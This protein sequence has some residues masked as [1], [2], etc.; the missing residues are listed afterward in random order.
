[1]ITSV[2]T[3]HGEAVAGGVFDGEIFGGEIVGLDQQAGCSF[4]LSGE[5]E[6][7]FVH[8]LA[9]DG[10]AVG[11]ERER[12]VEMELAFGEIDHVSGLGLD[13]LLLQMLLEFCRSLAG[14]CR[15]PGEQGQRE[16]EYKSGDRESGAGH[17]FPRAV[18]RKLWYTRAV[19]SG[20]A[21]CGFTPLP[22]RGQKE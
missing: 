18:R 6:D 17:G 11:G 3:L 13:Q 5:G 8:A 7:G 14:G 4:F 20:G 12:A 1:M 16:R 10:D 21:S 15:T 19:R 2:S 9:A 22:Y